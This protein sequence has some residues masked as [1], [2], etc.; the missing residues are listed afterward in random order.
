MTTRFAFYGRVS[1]EDNQ[2]PTASRAW[3]LDRSLALI[4]DGELVAEFFDI[5]QSRSLPWKRR[6]ESRRLL[7][8]VKSGAHDFDAIVV[9]ELARAFGDS[10]DQALTLRALEHYGV[11]LWHPDAAGR[12][13]RLNIGHRIT[14]AL[15]AELAQE[16]R[17]TIRRRVHDAM[18]SQA[19]DGRWL[20]G[21][22][23][24]G[25][26]LVEAGLHPNPGK[27]AL[28]IRE[29]RLEVDPVAAPIVARIFAEYLDG[30]GIYAI[31]EGLTAE[32]I[33]SPSGH[34]PARNRHRA[35]SGGAWGKS[36]VR[37]ILRNPVYAGRRVWGKQRRSEVAFDV[38]DFSLG[39][40]TKFV[41]NDRSAWV[42]SA[43]AS[44]EAIVDPETFARAQEVAAAGLHR[45]LPNGKRRTT[46]R[47]YLLSG[48]VACGLCGRRMQGSWNND[49]AHYRCRFAAEYALAKGVDHPKT[50]YLREDVLVPA[51]DRWLAELFDERNAE[52]AW[53]ALAMASR[54]HDEGAAARAEAARRKIAD[55]DERLARYRA[56]LDA[57][58]DAVVVAGWMAEVKGERLAAERELGASVPAE[59]LTKEQVRSLIAGLQDILAVLHDADPKLKAEVY[60]ELG[61]KVTYDPLSD[62]ATV[63][64]RP[65][66]AH[67][68]DRVRGGT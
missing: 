41:W 56:T 5:G 21:R 49:R 44:H 46:A 34:D 38:E 47:R 51:L 6:P 48:R 43:E 23:P 45:P 60:A 3:Q 20:G 16:E 22:P 62:R 55:C 63:S 19:R 37:T 12:H 39:N 33:P 30:R 15:R 40:R 32:G 53:E 1:T 68:Q 10:T 17:E 59:P 26:R 58:G 13:D 36:A 8:L 61:V 14:A 42:W 24:Y 66:P 7:D 50:V 54:S 29:K 25:Y 2:D 18:Q 28:G 57:G 52:A 31:A 35:S 4:G 9:G 27:A 64:A 11:E 65:G 67:V